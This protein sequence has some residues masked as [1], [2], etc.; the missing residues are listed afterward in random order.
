[1]GPVDYPE[2]STTTDLRCVTSQKSADLT[3]IAAETWNHVQ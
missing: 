3:H 2:T 1:M